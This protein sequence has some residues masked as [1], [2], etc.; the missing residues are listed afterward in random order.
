MSINVLAS[1]DSGPIGSRAEALVKSKPLVEPVAEFGCFRALVQALGSGEQPGDHLFQE[2]L[3]Q[4]RGALMH[5]MK[6]RGLLGQPPSYVGVVGGEWNDETIEEL[7]LD[8][9]EWI[10]VRRLPGL[11]R[12]LKVHKNIDGLVFR[13]IRNF[14]Y[15]SQKRNDPLGSRIYKITTSSV[16]SLVDEGV[17]W[18]SS[19]SLPLGKGVILRFNRFDQMGYENLT[20]DLSEFVEKWPAQLMPDLVTAHHHEA[21]R[22]KLSG[23]IVALR[24]ENV[25][26][27]RFDSLFKPL[28]SSSRLYWSA[29]LSNGSSLVFDS[30]HA[31]N[32]FVE[33]SDF[34]NRQAFT[35][36]ADCV[37]Q[38]LSSRP[39]SKLET[40]LKRFWA[41]L[42]SVAQE[43]SR[44]PSDR[45]LADLL[46]IPRARL[47][48]VRSELSRMVTQ[49]H[50]PC[51][52]RLGQVV[53]GR[54][55]SDEPKGSPGSSDG[56]RCQ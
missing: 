37:E 51:R 32:V 25:S 16:A 48:K 55:E 21:T 53:G 20:L 5:E 30:P 47:P 11:L 6:R 10:F 8:C 36:L 23:L 19:D 38:K 3:S 45:Q 42:R 7:L 26:S 22:D 52:G 43:D 12:Q 15:E 18:K 13:N 33:N 17:L 49:C 40:Y 46:E 28:A 54:S 9:Y 56:K 2:L 4:L 35:A 1:V 27:F 50:E 14:L 31:P 24:E 29:M 39:T 44:I 34:E 41:Y